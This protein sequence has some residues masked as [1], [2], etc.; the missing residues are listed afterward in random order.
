MRDGLLMYEADWISRGTTDDTS[1]PSGTWT[2]RTGAG[3][4]YFN[5]IAS[6]T[7][8]HGASLASPVAL[9][10]QSFEVE[11]V[12]EVDKIG[13]SAT[14]GFENFGLKQRSGSFKIKMLRDTT[15]DEA[16]ASLK[17]GEVVQF[18]VDFGELTISVTGKIESLAYD[19]DDL[20]VN[21][22]ACRILSTYTT[23]SVGEC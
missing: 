18:D 17:T 21:E 1:D 12:C 19:T 7:L 5:D 2:P 9:T 23:G 4:V 22:I 8:T 6:A 10:M 15:A 20:L 3:L 13:H 16:L 11:G 14:L